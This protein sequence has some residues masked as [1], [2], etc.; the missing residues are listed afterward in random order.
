[1]LLL[2]WGGFHHHTV[3]CH[4]VLW[5]PDVYE[6]YLGPTGQ[7]RPAVLQSARKERGPTQTGA[8]RGFVTTRSRF[9]WG[10]GH[11]HTR[12]GTF[13]HTVGSKIRVPITIEQFG[14]RLRRH[15]ETLRGSQFTVEHALLNGIGDEQPRHTGVRG[16]NENLGIE[17][18]NVAIANGTTLVAKK[19]KETF[20]AVGIPTSMRVM[21]LTLLAPSN[22]FLYDFF[23]TV[24]DGHRYNTMSD[25]SLQTNQ[26]PHET[27][28]IGSETDRFIAYILKNMPNGVCDART[29]MANPEFTTIKAEHFLEGYHDTL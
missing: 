13:D 16:A 18:L 22:V 1:M 23:Q 26:V 29:Y 4:A 14:Y 25:L 17:N 2:W 9:R 10:P 12:S 3:P 7:R 24:T 20:L 6:V 5:Q 11:P 8:H 28:H 19:L 27:V 15:A 21:S